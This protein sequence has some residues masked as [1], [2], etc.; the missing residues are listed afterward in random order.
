MVSELV[1]ETP[2]VPNI[3]VESEVEVPNPTT[4]G[5][6]SHSVVNDDAL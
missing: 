4:R 2:D 3:V 1:V 5:W 6:P